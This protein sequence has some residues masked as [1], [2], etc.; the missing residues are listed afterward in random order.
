MMS[1]IIL[2]LPKNPP[3]IPRAARRLLLLSILPISPEQSD[4]HPLKG[5]IMSGEKDELLPRWRL[6][7]CL[8]TLCMI[9]YNAT[10]S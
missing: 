4:P 7:T 5:A 9:K 1:R 2:L 6:M 10:C 8:Q 3:I